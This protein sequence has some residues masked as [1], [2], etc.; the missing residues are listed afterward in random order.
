M[1]EWFDTHC[2][3]DDPAFDPDREEVLGRMRQSRIFC[4]LMGTDLETSMRC[5]EIAVSHSSCVAAAGFHPES[6]NRFSGEAFLRLSELIA[7]PGVRAVGEIG[8]DYHWENAPDRQTQKDVFC[9]QLD[10]ACQARLPVC[11]HV[12]DAHGDMLDIL[13]NRKSHLPEGVIHCFSGSWESARRYLD[14]G[15]YLGL[16][17]PV[18]YRNA[19]R[20]QEIALR[21]PLNRLLLETDSPYLSPVPLR[22]QR[23]E[24]CHIHLI[25]EKIAEIRNMDAEDLARHTTMNAQ[26]FYHLQDT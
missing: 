15:F 23:N 10:L 20:P 7:K 1:T 19:T 5:M 2:H 13:E 9:A 8:L 3:L 17:G 11:I 12:R 21:I 25:G 14:L 22:G 26:R 16:D 4:A 24:P 18:T 6:A